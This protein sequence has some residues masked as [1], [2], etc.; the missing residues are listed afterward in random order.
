M[1]QSKVMMSVS[2]VAATLL[3]VACGSSDKAS[4]NEPVSAIPGVFFDGTVEGLDYVANGA[5]KLSTNAS[6]YFRY[7]KIFI[8]PASAKYMER[9]PKIA[10]TLDV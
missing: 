6:P 10:N 5:A 7:S 8:T 3:S 4:N 2:V 1:K 9:K